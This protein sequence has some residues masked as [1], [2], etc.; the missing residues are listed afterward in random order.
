MSTKEAVR[1]MENAKEILCTKA[2]GREGYYPD[3]KYVRMTCGTACCFNSP[4][5]IPLTKGKTAKSK[6]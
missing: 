3:V 4:R 1:Q 6:E 5:S 2:E